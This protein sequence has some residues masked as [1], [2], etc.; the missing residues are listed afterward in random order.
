[1]CSTVWY[2]LLCGEYP[3]KGQ[4]PEAIIWQVGK[5]VKQSLANMQ[6][7]RDIKVRVERIL[8]YLR[9]SSQGGHVF[10]YFPLLLYNY[11]YFLAF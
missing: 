7:S 4:P 10:R 3:F 11:F 6:A 1:M 8:H 2:E 5:G 9:K